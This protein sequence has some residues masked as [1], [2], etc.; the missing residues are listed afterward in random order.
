MDYKEKYKELLE[1]NKQLEKELE[2]FHSKSQEKTEI[3]RDMIF[4]VFHSASHLMAIS[5]LDTGQYVQG[6]LSK[7]IDISEN[8]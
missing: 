7:E 1:T 6:S 3:A 4:K 5:K 8:L 2:F